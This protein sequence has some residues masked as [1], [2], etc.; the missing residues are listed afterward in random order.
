[1]K[2]SMRINI[3]ILISILISAS[4]D[5]EKGYFDR[6]FGIQQVTT[7]AELAEG[8]SFDPFGVL[9]FSDQSNNRILKYTVD[10]DL[11]LFMQ[12]AGVSNGLLF[13]YDGRLL[14]CQSNSGNFPEDS[15]AGKRRI[16]R[17]EK[18]SS[19]TVLADS[20]MGNPLIGPNDLCMDTR[21]RIFFTDPYYPNPIVEKTQENSGVYRIDSVGHIEQI[22]SNLEKPNGILITP[23]NRTLYVSDRGT[24]KLHQYFVH[25]DGSVEH[26]KVVYD[27]SPDRGIDGMVMDSKGFIYGAAGEG[28]TTGVY[29]IDVENN[30]Q[31]DVYYTPEKAYNVA[32][33]GD[34]NK[35]LYVAAG[36]SIYMLRTVNKGLLLPHPKRE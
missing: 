36:G 15:L 22:I 23:D 3:I 24:Q 25:D 30:K 12:P 5:T 2:K 17:L 6:D 31:V 9:Y 21:E 16:A 8:P 11:K 28:E 4:C 10:G 13:D 29:V 18:D 26:Q 32:F 19:I 1:M 20:Y 34:D 33:D 35:D 27:F 7:G 14:M